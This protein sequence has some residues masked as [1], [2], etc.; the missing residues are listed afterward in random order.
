MPMFGG[1]GESVATGLMGMFQGIQQAK[2]RAE[3]MEHNKALLKVEQ[4]KLK[5][6]EQEIGLKGQSELYDFFLAKQQGQ[7]PVVL[8]P[9]EGLFPTT[10]GGAIAEQPALLSDLFLTLGEGEKA[11]GPGERG[12]LDPKAVVEGARKPTTP[13]KKS[14]AV[15]WAEEFVEASKVNGQETVSMKEALMMTKSKDEGS[16]LSRYVLVRMVRDI[17]MGLTLDPEKAMARL[18]AFMEEGK[19][20]FEGLQG[21]GEAEVALPAAISQILG[22]GK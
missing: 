3:T 20:V 9:G 19:G 1:R 22:G 6:M 15:E 16:F 5:L 7:Q 13:V 4:D 18:N 2:E 11:F 14:A 17:S 10:G 12:G 8:K 21:G